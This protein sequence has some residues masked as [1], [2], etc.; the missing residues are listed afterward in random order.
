MIST[1]T[2]VDSLAVDQLIRDGETL[3]SASGITEVGFLSP[4]DSKRRYLGIWY[5][6]ISPLTVVWVANRNTPLQNTS[7]VLKLNQK[8][9]LVLLNAT[10]SAIWSSN[11]SSTALGFGKFCSEKW[12]GN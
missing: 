7:G 12:T 3:V 5:R 9:F 4:G 6:N 10:N 8:G 11:I 1:S 2:S